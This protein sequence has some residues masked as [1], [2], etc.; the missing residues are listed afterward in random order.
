MTTNTD[1]VN[2]ILNNSQTIEE[3]KYLNKNISMKNCTQLNVN[4]NTKV[5]SSFTPI[6]SLEVS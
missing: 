6:I 5:N 4:S 1:S 2:L 3:N